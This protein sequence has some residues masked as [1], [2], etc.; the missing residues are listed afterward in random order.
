MSH[1][2]ADSPTPARA[3]PSR[4]LRGW[5][6]ARASPARARAA[7]CTSGGWTTP[8]N[9]GAARL[10]D[11]RVGVLAWCRCGSVMASGLGEAC[12]CCVCCVEPSC[13]QSPA[14]TNRNHL[15]PR[16]AHTNTPLSN[17]TSTPGITVKRQVSPGEGRVLDVQ[18]WGAAPPL[19][20]YST[21][22]GGVHGMDLRMERDAWVVPA[23]P[24]L[25]L[26]QQVGRG[27]L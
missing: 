13:P 21:Q 24:N 15:K 9:R 6:T 10:I 22:R 27:W 1:S 17:P 25:G 12:C 23:P 3:A 8:A 14:K 7:R 26:L 11:T 4:R 19:M 18:Q 5:R 16:T 20:I 2:A